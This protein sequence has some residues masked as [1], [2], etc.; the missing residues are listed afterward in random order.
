MTVIFSDTCTDTTGTN[1]Q[2][3]TPDIGAAAH[4]VADGPAKITAAGKVRDD[5]GSAFSFYGL[6]NEGA[7]AAEFDFSVKLTS[8]AVGITSQTFRLRFDRGGGGGDF[9]DVRLTGAGDW[10]LHKFISSVDTLIAS[11][12][13]GAIV[14]TTKQLLIELRTG[15]QIFKIDGS[16]IISESDTD[17]TLGG[18][19]YVLM[20]DSSGVPND[21][22]SIA[23]DDFV[24]DTITTGT[25]PRLGSG[26]V[27]GGLVH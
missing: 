24:I 21:A 3:H 15:S 12:S 25:L 5:N 26:L 2:S 10:E 6:N 9:Y 11:V 17:I 1:W 14:S 8:L 13:A 22:T 16:T 23:L 7:T 4:L 18:P 27:S 20:L 19:C